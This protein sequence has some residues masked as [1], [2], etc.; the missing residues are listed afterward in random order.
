MQSSRKIR[1][2]AV[3]YITR[4]D[5]LLVFSHPAFP[6][7]GIQVPAG[8]IEPGEAPEDAVLREAHEETGLSGLAVRSFLGIREYD[9]APYGK[10]EIECRH[11]FHLECTGEAPAVWR[12]DELY[13]SDGSPAP[14]EFELFWVKYPE[15]VPE[16]IGEQGAL[17]SDLA[18]QSK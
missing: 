12:H 6:E 8:T 18:R 11:F 9:L 16:L 10:A 5:Q 13:P 3:A 7:A 1:N 15:D 14:I 4:G 2:K 17:L